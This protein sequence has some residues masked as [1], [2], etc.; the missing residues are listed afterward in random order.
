MRSHATGHWPPSHR[1]HP[2]EYSL[3]Q[4]SPCPATRT[5]VRHKRSLATSSTAATCRCQCIYLSALRQPC[6]NHARANPPAPFLTLSLNEEKQA[7]TLPCGLTHIFRG[8][9]ASS[10][11]LLRAR[12]ALAAARPCPSRCRAC[13]VPA[14]PARAFTAPAPPCP[15]AHRHC[16]LRIRSHAPPPSQRPGRAPTARQRAC[17]TRPRRRSAPPAAFTR[18]WRP[19]ATASCTGLAEPRWS[20]R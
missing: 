1:R 9:G 4:A 6:A 10:M 7:A 14:S 3:L 12:S 2:C 15:S 11:S 17:S 20:F 8:R 13:L 16:R 18:E 5:H 19:L